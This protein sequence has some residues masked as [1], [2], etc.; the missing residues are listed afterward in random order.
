MSQQAKS[1][2]HVS[3]IEAGH[4]STLLSVKIGQIPVSVVACDGG[5]AMFLRWDDLP[6][7]SPFEDD[8]VSGVYAPDEQAVLA[9][10]LPVGATTVEVVAP[11]G[12]RIQGTV[13][14]GAWIAVLPDNHRGIEAYPVLF[15]HNDG[16]PVIRHIPADWDR[17]TAIRDE[18]CPACLA[19]DWDL[20]TAPWEG[21]G[22][23]RSTHWGH[24]GNNPGQAYVCRDCGHAERLGARWQY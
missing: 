9:G 6:A 14:S 21:H 5:G 1:E 2:T 19:T 7:T 15:R 17:R 8:Q 3:P 24:H 11:N 18:P 22:P 23:Q 20:V 10:R 4:E 16:A 12:A 13:G